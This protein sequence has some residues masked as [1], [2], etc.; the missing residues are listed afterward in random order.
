MVSVISWAR[1]GLAL[2]SQR[3]GVMPLVLLLNFAGQNSAK[4]LQDFESSRSS[5]WSFA[6]PF[7][8]QDPTM[9]RWAMRT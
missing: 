4:S 6:T 7:T 1:A 3:R 9:A 5:V 2:R 8:E